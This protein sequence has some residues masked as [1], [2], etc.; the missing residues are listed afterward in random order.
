MD[1]NKDAQLRGEFEFAESKLSYE[2]MDE[3]TQVFLKSKIMDNIHKYFYMIAFTAYIRQVA[4]LA[5]NSASDEDKA[6]NAMTGEKTAIPADQLKVNKTFDQ[7]M[8]EHPDLRSAAALATLEP[9][10]S[11]D[12]KTN[13]GKIINDIHQNAHNIV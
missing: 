3:A 6:K 5:R 11:S 1:M 2:I 8:D 10:A 4:N 12:F 7:F 13:I 9:L